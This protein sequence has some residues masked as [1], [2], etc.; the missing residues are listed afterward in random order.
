MEEKNFLEHSNKHHKGFIIGYTTEFKGSFNL[1]F[2]DK[3]KEEY[4]V[5]LVNDLAST[6][7]VKR[8]LSKIQDQLDKPYTDYG[9]EGEFYTEGKGFMGQ[10]SDPSVLNNN[11]PPSTQPSLW[12]QWVINVDN[13]NYILEWNQE[14]KFYNYTEWL[15]Y[16]IEKIFKPCNVSISGSVEYRGEEWSDI[17]TITIKDYKVINTYTN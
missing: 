7:R 8:D 4:V 5:K 12:Q 9:I 2:N 10:D 15:E 17:G 13:D 6:R 3:T 14:E 16:L 11:Y 1:K